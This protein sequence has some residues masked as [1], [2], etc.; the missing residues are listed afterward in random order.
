MYDAITDP[1]YR[2]PK[3]L[4]THLSASLSMTTAVHSDRP[5][6]LLEAED[7]GAPAAGAGQAGH[8]RRLH[9]IRAV[10]GHIGR[11]LWCH[12]MTA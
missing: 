10:V 8:R 7:G 11:E 2:T 5:G 1:T 3:S 4:P 12:R 9:G 6:D